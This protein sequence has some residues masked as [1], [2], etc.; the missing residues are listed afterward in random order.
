[1]ARQNDRGTPRTPL[2]VPRTDRTTLPSRR[3]PAPSRRRSTRRGGARPLRRVRAPARVRTKGRTRVTFAHPIRS[4]RVRGRKWRRIGPVIVVLGRVHGRREHRRIRKR[5]RPASS[6]RTRPQRR[7]PWTKPACGRS[8]TE[9]RTGSSAPQPAPI[10][11]TAKPLSLVA[12]PDCSHGAG[13]N[14]TGRN[15]NTVSFRI[16]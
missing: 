5:L 11:R 6:G 7:R 10:V 13:W 15:V 4:R 3:T 9:T 14:P 16:H 2:T 8:R 1:M 12:Y